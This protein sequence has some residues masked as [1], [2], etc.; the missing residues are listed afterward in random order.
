MDL[1][2]E[3]VGGSRSVPA[4]VPREFGKRGTFCGIV[5]LGFQPEFRDF[6]LSGCPRWPRRNGRGRILRAPHQR[7][8]PSPGKILRK[9]RNFLLFPFCFL[10]FASPTWGIPLW[11]LC[12]SRSLLDSLS[13]VW[14]NNSQLPV[15]HIL[16][17]SF[18]TAMRVSS[19]WN[20]SWENAAF[21]PLFPLLRPESPLC[22]LSGT[23][24]HRFPV[25]TTQS[26]ARSSFFRDFFFLNF[27]FFSPPSAAPR[28]GGS[29]QFRAL[30]AALH[31]DLFPR[32]DDIPGSSQPPRH[33]RIP[34][35]KLV[36]SF[37]SL[38]KD[39]P[40]SWECSSQRGI[41]DFM[42]FG[43]EAELWV[44]PGNL[45]M[46]R[47]RNS[48]FGERSGNCGGAGMGLGLS[49]GK[50]PGLDLHG[51]RGW[52]VERVQGMELEQWKKGMENPEGSRGG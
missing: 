8:Q 48:R 19:P 18:E 38:S 52:E 51:M 14:C 50:N 12:P 2:P 32:Q 40:G 35:P 13:Q 16:A 26:E 22:V 31:A 30:Q 27:S 36:S 9:T 7:H 29:D 45:E 33:V 17:G 28:P 10:G 5:Q 47:S 6:P 20:F 34:T 25:D 11:E 23:F 42:R 1:P 41:L 21:P 39:F 24:H 3:L 46:G 44:V 37:S 43:D 49:S 15:D 4:P